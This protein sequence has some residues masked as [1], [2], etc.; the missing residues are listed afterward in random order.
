L[1][2]TI[3]LG[4]VLIPVL[5]RRGLDADGLHILGGVIRIFHPVSLGSLGVVILTGAMAL[6][7]LKETLGPQFVPRLFWLLS[8]KLLLVFVLVLVS[9]YQFFGLGLRF[10]KNLPA[11]GGRH[12]EDVSAKGIQLVR[13]LQTWNLVAAALGAFIVYL[14]L[15]MSR[16]G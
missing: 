14:G 10:L 5:R 12:A 9:S 7:P 2:G 6:T 4:G 15:R 16:P 1:G 3:F 13:R 8:I 11:E